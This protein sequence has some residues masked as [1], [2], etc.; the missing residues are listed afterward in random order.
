MQVFAVNE[1]YYIYKDKYKYITVLDADEAIIPRQAYNQELNETFYKQYKKK[2]DDDDGNNK[3]ISYLDQ[4][5]NYLSH[6]GV[7]HIINELKKIIKLEKLLKSSNY[8][9]YEINV[10]NE[11]VSRNIYKIRIETKQQ[12]DNMLNS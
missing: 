6:E 11:Q 2:D 3:F 1:C 5:N 12:L 10:L 8:S 9:N 4:L 7:N